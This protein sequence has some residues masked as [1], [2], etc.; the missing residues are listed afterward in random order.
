MRTLCANIMQVETCA[1]FD[2]RPSHFK[3]PQQYLKG[4]IISLK[5]SFPNLNGYGPLFANR[6][7]YPVVFHTQ[8]ETV[9]RSL[10]CRVAL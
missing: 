6:R 4:V 9:R 10:G 1:I 8:A 2:R 5:I 7:T 3:A